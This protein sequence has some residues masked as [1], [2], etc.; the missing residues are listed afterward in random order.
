[1]LVQRDEMQHYR[2]GD[3]ERQQVVKRIEAG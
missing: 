3:D 2:A 1:M